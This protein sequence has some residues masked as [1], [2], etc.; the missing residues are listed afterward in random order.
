MPKKYINPD[1][2]FDSAQY[3]FSQVVTSTPGRLVFISGQTAWDRNQEIVGKNDLA[4][5]T[6]QSLDNLKAAI[7]STGGSVADITMLRIYVVDETP[8]ANLIIGKIIKEFFGTST[9]PT[10]T[11]IGVRS[12]AIPEFLIEIEAQAVIDN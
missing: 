2:L 9:P 10:S 11:W 4:V 12:L 5:Q 8:D 7:E 6:K 1:L 3:G